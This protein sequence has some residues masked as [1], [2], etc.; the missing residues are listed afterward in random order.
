MDYM[1]N[2]EVVNDEDFVESDVEETSEEEV[3]EENTDTIE[4]VEGEVVDHVT[5]ENV[6]PVPPMG[7]GGGLGDMLGAMMGGMMPPMGEDVP[8]PNTPEEPVEEAEEDG[9]EDAPFV[10]NVSQPRYETSV[11]LSY[12][13]YAKSHATEF[14]EDGNPVIS[15]AQIDTFIETLRKS[16]LAF[17]ENK[18]PN[19]M[20]YRKVVNCF[21]IDGMLAFDAVLRGDYTIKIKKTL[22]NYEKNAVTVALTLDL[23]LYPDEDE[24]VEGVDEENTNADGQFADP[25][26]G[27]AFGGDIPLA[28]DANAVVDDLHPIGEPIENANEV[29]V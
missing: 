26:G 2:E 7:M 1:N 19:F 11:T 6:P 18:K 22:V 10:D 21:E 5:A 4:S 15:D 14:D 8:A 17:D 24:P 16:M 23:K 20:A 3:K 13:A 28:T 25:E 9:S 12:E 29:E 27:P